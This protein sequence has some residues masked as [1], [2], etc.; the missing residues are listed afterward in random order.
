[1]RDVIQVEGVIEQLEPTMANITKLGL[2]DK[3]C[4]PLRLLARP[5]VNS[6][7]NCNII[8]ASL[9]NNLLFSFF[10][11]KL[12]SLFLHKGTSTALMKCLKFTTPPSTRSLAG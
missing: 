5:V 12:I 2:L 10:L 6:G 4:V 11:K 3:M 9:Y 1:M 8:D 7:D